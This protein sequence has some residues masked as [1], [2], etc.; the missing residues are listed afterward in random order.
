MIVYWTVSALSHDLGIA[1]RTLYAV[2]NNVARHYHAVQIPRRDGTYRR[3]SIPDEALKRIQRAICAHLL[4]YMPVSPYATAYRV[5]GSIF[6]N[7]APHTGKTKVL[8]LDIGQGDG[9]S[10]GDFL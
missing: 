8:R 4:V 3:L 6:R 2:S 7:A 10:S 5:G 1:A 9:L